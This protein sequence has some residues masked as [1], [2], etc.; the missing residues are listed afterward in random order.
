M[1]LALPRPPPS[2]T[3]SSSDEEKNDCWRK[4][5]QGR[6]HCCSLLSALPGKGS[7]LMKVTLAGSDVEMK[8]ENLPIGV[9]YLI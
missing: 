1:V 7:G 2:A 8:R 3:G 5:M 6:P 9:R 4:S